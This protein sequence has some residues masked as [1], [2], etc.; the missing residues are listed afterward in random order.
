MTNHLSVCERTGLVLLAN[1]CLKLLQAHPLSRTLFVFVFIFLLMDGHS[2]I[3]M[4]LG[5]HHITFG[6]FGGP[7]AHYTHH[8]HH[9]AHYAPFTTLLDPL[10]PAVIRAVRKLGGHAPASARSPG[11]VSA[12][13]L[14]SLTL[15]RC[16]RRSTLPAMTA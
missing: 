7:L 10:A 13:G 4:P 1:E 12:S 8:V 2:G 9:D 16:H 3:D 5:Y 15:Q 14:S 6:V 11:K